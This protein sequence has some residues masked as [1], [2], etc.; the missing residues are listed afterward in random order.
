[1]QE[2]TMMV[3]VFK[4]SFAFRTNVLRVMNSVCVMCKQVH[5]FLCS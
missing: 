3:F 1:M 4:M 2:S 5:K